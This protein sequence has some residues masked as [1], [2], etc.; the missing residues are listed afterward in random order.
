MNKLTD[1]ITVTGQINIEDIK[2]IK[3]AGYEIIINNRPDREEDGQPLSDDLEKA[4][5]ELGLEFCH[6][7]LASGSYPSPYH[8]ESMK[9]VLS[10]GKKTLC[11]CRSGGRSANLV[12][13][14]VKK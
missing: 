1:K 14:S 6:I 12:T 10:K 5:K 13:L 7:P 11:F 8:L 4:A 3:D 9:E 2:C